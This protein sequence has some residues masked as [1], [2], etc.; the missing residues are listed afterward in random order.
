MKFYFLENFLQAIYRTE[1]K[2]II[3]GTQHFMEI[4][5]Y[6]RKKSIKKISWI[7]KDKTFSLKSRKPKID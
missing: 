2:E 4:V 3:I 1:I 6:D 7:P 5:Y